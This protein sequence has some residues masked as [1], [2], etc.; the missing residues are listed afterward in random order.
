MAVHEVILRRYIKDGTIELNITDLVTELTRED[1]LSQIRTQ[2]LSGIEP[3]VQPM[4]AMVSLKFEPSTD[5]EELF[6]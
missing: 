4:T 1:V 6:L 5:L 2:V 3:E